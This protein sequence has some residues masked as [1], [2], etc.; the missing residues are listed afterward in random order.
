MLTQDEI[1][2]WLAQAY[3]PKSVCRL[4]R[5]WVQVLAATDA[6]E[7]DVY[8]AVLDQALPVGDGN[9]AV[10]VDKPFVP[11][12]R[13]N[14]DSQLETGAYVDPEGRIWAPGGHNR[15]RLLRAVRKV[16]GA[17]ADRIA[18]DKRRWG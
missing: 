16:A 17:V 3:G 13:P 10:A 6:G 1:C 11:G 2:R 15:E 14:V 5:R 9:L 8:V 12:I 7:V 18:L 4:G